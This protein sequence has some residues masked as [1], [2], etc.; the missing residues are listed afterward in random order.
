MSPTL[1]SDEETGS[2]RTSSHQDHMSIRV[3]SPELCF[4]WPGLHFLEGPA[5]LSCV[6]A[7]GQAGLGLCFSW[8]GGRNP[9]FQTGIY[10]S[11]VVCEVVSLCGEGV[12]VLSHLWD[13]LSSPWRP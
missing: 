7:G 12:K 2:D 13:P 5:L 9:C 4:F 1:L 10:A 6:T 11:Q 8:Q 3:L